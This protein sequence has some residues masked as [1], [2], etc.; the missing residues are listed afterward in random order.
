MLK[1]DFPK[2]GKEEVKR[3][4]RK[5]TIKKKEKEGFPIEDRKKVKMEKIGGK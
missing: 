5:R 2:K 4:E 1:P 3:K